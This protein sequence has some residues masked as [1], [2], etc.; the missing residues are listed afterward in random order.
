VAGDKPAETFP[1]QDLPRFLQ[2]AGNVETQTVAPPAP[3]GLLFPRLKPAILT[4]L[5]FVLRPQPA[6]GQQAR[7]LIFGAK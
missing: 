2:G 4:D 1:A 5:R 3:S 7:P 6:D